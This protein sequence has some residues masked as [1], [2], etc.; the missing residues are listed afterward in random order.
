MIRIAFLFALLLAL[1]ACADEE[2]PAAAQKSPAPTDVSIAGFAFEPP[3]IEVDRGDSVTWVNRDDIAHTVTSGRPKRQGIPG[4][5]DDRD[6]EPDGTFDSGT[7][8]LDD[9]FTHTFGEQ[10]AF[11]YYCAIHAGMKARVVV[12]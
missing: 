9:A 10:G 4:V 11:V 3:R 6:A 12:R 7:M 1:P 2:P 8:E 5:S